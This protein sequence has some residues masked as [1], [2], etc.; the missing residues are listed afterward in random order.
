MKFN[1]LVLL[2]FMAFL[3][4]GSATKAMANG[5]ILWKIVDTC[6]DK[7]RPQY[8][9]TCFS[10]R[11]DSGCQAK[12]VCQKSTDVWAENND[13]VAMRDIKMCGCPAD[14][15]HGLVMPKSLVSGIEDPKRPLGIWQFAWDVAAARL[16][17]PSIGL[18]VNSLHKRTQHHLHVHIVRLKPDVQPEL[19]KHLA[20]LVS[21]LNEVWAV[22]ERAAFA[23]GM[24]EHGILV[25]QAPNGQYAVSITLES[26]EG[27]WTQAF[28]TNG[29][30]S[31][32]ETSTAK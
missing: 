19:T 15:V 27:Q 28:C 16:D 14:F 21:D 4:M 2:S 18:A 5:H 23:K 9:S 17:G 1:I 7:S 31:S 20:G 11:T 25:A 3:W 32:P 12:P 24:P 30:V 8:C 22:A 26:P 13:F 6:V 10:P 29:P